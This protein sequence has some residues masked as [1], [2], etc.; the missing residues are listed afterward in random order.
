MAKTKT[1]N[2]AD[3]KITAY[4]RRELNQDQVLMLAELYEAALM[5]HGDDVNASQNSGISLIKVTADMEMIDGRH[6]KEAM[7]LAGYKATKV[8]EESAL[9]PVNLLS[10]AAQANIGGSLPP[11][12][13]DIQYIV[14][15]FMK[16]G[17]AAPA[18][19]S[20]MPWLPVTV[21]NK[22]LKLASN[23]LAEVRMKLAIQAVNGGEV[24]LKQAA[25][26][27]DVKEEFLAEKI[28]GKRVIQKVGMAQINGAITRAFQSLS[29]TVGTQ[30]S[31]VL[32]DFRDGEIP[33]RQAEAV[34]DHFSHLVGRLNM[35]IADWKNR[36]NKAKVG[37]P[38]DKDAMSHHAYPEKK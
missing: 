2:L 38:E 19:R 13:E 14:E 36:L 9:S 34:I 4:A 11:K 18:I 23:H 1:V 21:V 35:R 33:E 5:Q 20:A 8:I 10:Q 37:E 31:N 27:Y 12:R 3:I 24:S 17:L 22:Y 7:E 30:I 15:Q 16:M 32:E 29:H 25:K 28:T 6:R 26:T